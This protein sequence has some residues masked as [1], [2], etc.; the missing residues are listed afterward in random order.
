MQ[1]ESGTWLTS[2]PPPA[3]GSVQNRPKEA[4]VIRALNVLA[5]RR[6]A[7]LFVGVLS[8]ALCSGVHQTQDVGSLLDR[9][10]GQRA[11][12]A[13]PHSRR[14]PE[15]GHAGGA[16]ARSGGECGGRPPNRR[17]QDNLTAAGPSA[18]RSV[19]GSPAAAR[20]RTGLPPRPG[21]TWSLFTRT[22]G[23]IFSMAKTTSWCN[24]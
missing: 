21:S 1:P 15:P 10:V 20:P 12:S 4:A 18:L 2:C 23:R 11:G 14:A 19:R 5:L 3:G 13:P 24:R 17:K 9:P 16:P 8:G 22:P 7:A 6:E